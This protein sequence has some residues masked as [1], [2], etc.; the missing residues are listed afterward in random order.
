MILVCQIVKSYQNSL[1]QVLLTTG[2][3]KSAQ[4]VLAPMKFIACAVKKLS[5]LT[6][7][8]L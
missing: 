3:E 8:L 6:K 2:N 7:Q 1:S 5:S 4:Y